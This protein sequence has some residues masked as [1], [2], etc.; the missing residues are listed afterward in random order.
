[1]KMKI[2]GYSEE[3]ENLNRMK[4]VSLLCNSNDLEL[5]IQF[6][7]YT[8]NQLKKHG[9]DFGHEHFRDWLKQENIDFVGSDIIIVGE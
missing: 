3:S 2:Y 1:M 9:K 5:I 7:K 4:E 6:L 8:Q